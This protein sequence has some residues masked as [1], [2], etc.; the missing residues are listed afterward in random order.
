[1]RALNEPCLGRDTER[2]AALSRQFAHFATT[3]MNMRLQ[4]A[5]VGATWD[6]DGASVLGPIRGGAYN[7]SA[8]TCAA[9]VHSSACHGDEDDEDDGGGGGSTYYIV[10]VVCSGGGGGGGGGS[11][12]VKLAGNLLALYESQ[13]I[14][15]SLHV[16]LHVVAWLHGCMG[17]VVVVEAGEEEEER[18]YTPLA[19]RRQPAALSPSGTQPMQPTQPQTTEPFTVNVTLT[20]RHFR[21]LASEK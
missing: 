18:K 11:S 9:G 19:S 7:G 5:F 10:V 15:T 1:M 20:P 6:E 21:S 17:Y 8:G 14:C 3:N 16:V 12:V 4:R 2:H 13:M